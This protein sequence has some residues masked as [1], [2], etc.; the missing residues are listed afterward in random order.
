MYNK[1]TDPYELCFVLTRTKCS[2]M[3]RAEEVQ[4]NLPSKFPSFIKLMLPSH[5]AGGF[6]L[7]ISQNSLLVFLI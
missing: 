4:S 7:V 3:E 5:V 2:P 1:V 6:W